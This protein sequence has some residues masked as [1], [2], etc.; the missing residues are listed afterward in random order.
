MF[1]K[2]DA[3]E[4]DAEVWREQARGFETAAEAAAAIADDTGTAGTEA[5]WKGPMPDDR[6]VR[7]ENQS[8]DAVRAAD[9]LAEMAK[10]CRIIADEADAA[11]SAI[12]DIRSDWDD[13]N[14][15]DRFGMGGDADDVRDRFNERTAGARAS[16]ALL[17]EDLQ[18]II[19]AGDPLDF[20]FDSIQ[21]PGG[22]DL[23]EQ[24]DEEAAHDYFDTG[25]LVDPAQVQEIEDT[26]T[27]LSDGED[28]PTNWN[29]WA[30][31][32]GYSPEEV[33][34]ALDNLD[35][36]ERA[37][38]D[39]W[40]EDNKGD[41]NNDETDPNPPALGL[42][43][44][45]LRNMR[46]DQIEEF[47][48]DVP[49]LEPTLFRDADGWVDGEV[50]MTVNFDITDGGAGIDDIDQGGIGDCATLASLAAAVAA[51]PTFVDRHIQENENGTYTVTLYDEAGNPVEVTVS[52]YIPADDG[53][54]AYNGRDLDGEIN[55]ASIYE[56]AMAQYQGG[57]YV[58][59]NGA[60][61]ADRVT[62]TSGEGSTKTDLPDDDLYAEMRDAFEDG[63]P[64]VMGG[65]GHAY[66][67][68]GFDDDGNVLVMNPWGGDGRTAA[69][70]PEEFQSGQFPEPNDDWP[71]FNYVAVT[72]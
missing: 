24:I 3:F 56:K 15:I 2:P 37:A 65:G 22:P 28:P 12:D 49:N 70:T 16:L 53:N 27:G 17:A 61:T 7:M 21:V 14:F 60:Y 25:N 41:P 11:I 47:H 59:I 46:S 34:A 57:H 1:S 48:N 33:Q 62:T 71:E 72:E 36:D 23:G 51:D 30:S 44:F 10:A 26:I 38:L 45:L 5:V 35:D 50:D 43:S 20:L 68:V 31:L 67:V 18:P 54:P 64:I 40:L 58:E 8:L 66:A 63:K 13:G 32:N 29:L 69:M 6:L 19:N 4:H 55:W 52:G 39:Q 9:T 42:T